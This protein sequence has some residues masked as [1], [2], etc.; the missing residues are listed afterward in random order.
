MRYYAFCQYR[1]IHDKSILDIT[2]K[3]KNQLV[4][5]SGII[6][7]FATATIA[8]SSYI[9][10][11][12]NA[13][14]SPGNSGSAYGNQVIKPCAQSG[15]GSTNWGGAVSSAAQDPSGHGIGDFRANGCKNGVG[16]NNGQG[17]P[18]VC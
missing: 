6:I 7:L 12:A 3:A 1:F 13:Q 5:I 4:V 9:A 16:T 14:T 17:S 2:M 8:T 18:G 11:P 10:Q 15:C